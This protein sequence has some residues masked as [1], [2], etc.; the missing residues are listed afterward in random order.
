VSIDEDDLLAGFLTALCGVFAGLSC[1]ARSGD[2]EPKFN[3][4]D[5]S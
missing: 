3:I 4:G 2:D 1:E 5:R